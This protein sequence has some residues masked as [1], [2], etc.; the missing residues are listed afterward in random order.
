MPLLIAG[1]IGAAPDPSPPNPCNQSQFPFLNGEKTPS[2]GI[3]VLLIDGTSEAP[4][5]AG[6]SKKNK[7]PIGRINPPFRASP[8]GRGPSAKP[9][10][11][12]WGGETAHCGWGDRPVNRGS[13]I[14]EGT[15]NR[16]KKAKSRLEEPVRDFLGLVGGQAVIQRRFR[17]KK[18]TRFMRSLHS[19][20]ECPRSSREALPDSGC[21]PPRWRFSVGHSRDARRGVPRR[22]ARLWDRRCRLVLGVR[23][24]SLSLGFLPSASGLQCPGSGMPRCA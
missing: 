1:R 4:D 11:V 6:F 13:A 9:V 21:R 7:S 24:L 18:F 5:R 19:S 15:R 23:P 14:S 8:H 12:R 20:L 16:G 10:A 2:D 3:R 22:S 17:L